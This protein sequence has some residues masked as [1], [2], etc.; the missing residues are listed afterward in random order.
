MNENLSALKKQEMNLSTLR[1]EE[2]KTTRKTK[3][4]FKKELSFVE[5]LLNVFL[6]T[7][8]VLHVKVHEGREFTDSED[9]C[10][11]ISYRIFR[12]VYWAFN[13][14]LEGYYDVSMAL[15]RIAFENHLLL[16]Y[17]SKNEKEAKL[18]FEG[19][20]FAP[21]FLRK[22]VK[23]RDSLYRDMSEFIHSSFKSTFAFTKTEKEEQFG[24]L[25]EYD[26]EQFK[27]VHLL[28]IMTLFTSIVW[29]FCTIHEILMSEE[30]CS[31][32]KDGLVEVA[33]YIRAETSKRQRKKRVEAT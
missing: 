18:W 7:F 15:L 13:S 26:T 3:K 23:W 6:K 17:L 8:K 22:H 2:L 4:E 11:R 33:K 19:K 25:G 29:L 14:S 21:A 12:I 9:A 20:R 30:W 32:S 24:T 28:M 5:H 16:V 27:N 10:F 31:Y 1:K